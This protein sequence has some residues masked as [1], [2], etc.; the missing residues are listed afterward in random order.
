MPD[1]GARRESTPTLAIVLFLLSILLPSYAR[2]AS[3]DIA[4]TEVLDQARAATTVAGTCARPDADRLIQAFC[5]GRLRIG[6]RRSYPPFSDTTGDKRS[7][8]EIDIARA[9]VGR[10]Q[11][12]D[13]IARVTGCG[14][15]QDNAATLA[16]GLYLPAEDGVERVVIAPG[17]K[18]RRVGT[19]ADRLEGPPLPQ[20]AADH[21]THDVL[22][23]RG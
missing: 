9:I 14:D 19:E 20:E 11:R 3:P 21:L 6:V 1:T 7:G 13:D 23:I 5:S 8:F 12:Q 16:I 2:A 18:D 15:T 4:L 10:L 17:R 22:G